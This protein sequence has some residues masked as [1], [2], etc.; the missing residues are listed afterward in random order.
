MNARKTR[1]FGFERLEERHMLS[2]VSFSQELRLSARAQDFSGA[3]RDHQS[4]T[5]EGVNIPS[6]VVRAERP[7][8]YSQVTGAAQVTHTTTDNESGTTTHRFEGQVVSEGDVSSAV[9]GSDRGFS[10]DR[11]F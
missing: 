10:H 7:T 6:T 1:T 9:L 8:Q 3:P 4:L 2:S 11:H 5:L